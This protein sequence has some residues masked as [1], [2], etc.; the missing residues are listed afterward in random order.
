M[1]FVREFMG[2]LEKQSKEILS[3]II[4]FWEGLDKGDLVTG[5][6]VPL[7]AA[8]LA[9]SLAERA[10]RR[11]VNSRL[12]IEIN[13]LRKEIESNKNQ[14]EQ[15]VSVIDEQN[16]RKKA[17]TYP[18]VPYKD[19]LINVIE[20]IEIIFKE[21]PIFNEFF[22]AG[23]NGITVVK[24]CNQYD[25]N[26]KDLME[27]QEDYANYPEIPEEKKKQMLD[28]IT[29]QNSLKRE[30]E[31]E[32]EP[33]NDIFGKLDNLLYYIEKHKIGENIPAIEENNEVSKCLQYLWN[34]LQ[35]YAKIDNPLLED[36]LEAFKKLIIYSSHIEVF[37]DV[38]D[39]DELTKKSRK[40]RL[41]KCVPE[42]QR[43]VDMYSKYIEWQ[44]LRNQVENFEFDIL[45]TKWSRFQDDLVSINNSDLYLRISDFYDGLSNTIPSGEDAKRIVGEAKELLKALEKLE[46]KMKKKI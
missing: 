22:L 6:V 14:F 31:A 32:V 1:G 20:K 30:I 17:L 11:K 26:E 44:T 16:L 46:A 24:L 21:H 43:M 42:D 19:L 33:G 27:M 34:V 8:F 2:Y 40:E 23:K 29:E 28:L 37:E 3:N 25:L 4:A 5:V 45:T 38:S 15:Y 18:F 35:K 39:M 7:V 10:S 12:I 9:Y 13:W 41:A 36:A